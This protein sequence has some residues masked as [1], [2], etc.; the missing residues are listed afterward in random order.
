MLIEKKVYRNR[1]GEEGEQRDCAHADGHIRVLQVGG[2]GQ[3]R[4]PPHKEIDERRAQ[5]S[6]QHSRHQVAR[7]VNAQVEP[8]IALKRG[9]KSEEK[10]QSAMAEEPRDEEN[11][12]PRIARMGGWKTVGAAAIAIDNVNP[13]AD[14][15]VE[16]ART[17][18]CHRRTQKLRVAGIGE[19]ENRT[20]RQERDQHHFPMEI[21][22]HHIDERR[23]HRNPLEFA[24]DEPHKRVADG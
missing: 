3:F 19:R 8:R 12:A 21:P 4:E 20:H 9:P 15:I 13:R 5:E 6:E 17:Q 11:E 24:A 18:P 2:N 1:I 22:Q 14:G 23:V 16:V 10:R 7:V